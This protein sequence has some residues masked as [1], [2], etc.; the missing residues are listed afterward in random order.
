MN[1]QLTSLTICDKSLILHITGQVQVDRQCL[2]L[3]AIYMVQ[4]RLLCLPCQVLRL[5]S[6]INYDSSAV[7]L[8][9]TEHTICSGSVKESVCGRSFAQTE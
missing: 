8:S 6:L 3:L 9:Q 7:V 5:H 1:G 2:Q 4:R